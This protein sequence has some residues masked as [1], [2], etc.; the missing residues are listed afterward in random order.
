MEPVSW[1]GHRRPSHHPNPSVSQTDVGFEPNRN[2]YVVKAVLVILVILIKILEVVVVI[3]ALVLE[4]LA[5]EVV[6]S[7]GNDLTQEPAVSGSLKGKQDGSANLLLQ[8][9]TNLVVDLELLLDRLE[10]ILFN[11]AALD[12]LLGRGDWWREEV[13]E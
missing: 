8:V 13:E 5:G 9:L 7:T 3:V 1:P 11:V 4:S 10:L 12:S 6:D 2:T